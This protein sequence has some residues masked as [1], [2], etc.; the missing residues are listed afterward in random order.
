MIFF[1]TFFVLNRGKI[2]DWIPRSEF[3]IP[4]AWTELLR[5]EKNQGRLPKK[6]SEPD[7]D[8][9]PLPCRRHLNL[10][11]L[12]AAPRLWGLWASSLADLNNWN[13][14]VLTTGNVSV[15]VHCVWSFHP[16]VYHWLWVQEDLNS[17][18]SLTVAD[19]NGF[20]ACCIFST[21]ILALSIFFLNKM[22]ANTLC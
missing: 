8:C 11:W 3:F 13:M 19:L 18:F 4:H 6:R 14:N 9:L 17:A 1:K 7:Y 5:N 10:S 22:I 12:A 21:P 20:F 2:I 15:Y 16:V